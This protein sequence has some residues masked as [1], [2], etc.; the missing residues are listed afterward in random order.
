MVV[1]EDCSSNDDQQLAVS[2]SDDDEV[3]KF[4]S[5]LNPVTDC[6]TFSHHSYPLILTSSDTN[7][8]SIII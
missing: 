8:C 5:A 7:H 3:G 2:T 1:A 6:V 4:S